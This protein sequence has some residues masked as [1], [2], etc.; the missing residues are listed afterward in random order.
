MDHTADI[1]K[2]STTSL[3]AVLSNMR[4]FTVVAV[5]LCSINLLFVAEAV[6]VKKHKS[7]TEVKLPVE[8]GENLSIF[9]VSSIVFF[10]GFLEEKVK[11]EESK[12]V[13]KLEAIK[14]EQD[15]TK[16]AAEK[17]KTEEDKVSY[18]NTKVIRI[19]VKSKQEQA[20]IK[21]L[22]TDGGKQCYERS[23]QSN[24]PG[25]LSNVFPM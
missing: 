2:A 9:L 13:E 5:V 1:I 8:K 14:S 22:E 16:V 23:A 17:V 15:E 11:V 4:C 12:P 20:F 6:S 25:L 3:G 18:Q 7:E 24:R 10:C 19:T 21:A